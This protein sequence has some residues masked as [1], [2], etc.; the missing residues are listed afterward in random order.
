MPDGHHYG[1]RHPGNHAQCSLW[2]LLSLL[3][4][5]TAWLAEGS[6]LPH[7][8]LAVL[9]LAW[10]KGALLIEYYMGLRHAPLWLRLLVQGWLAVVSA[11]LLFSFLS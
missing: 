5:F 9:G 7:L 2:L 11:A 1:S 3:T 10:F 4:V 6:H 8:A